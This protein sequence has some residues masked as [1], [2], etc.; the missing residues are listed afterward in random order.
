M[1]ILKITP[2]LLTITI[3]FNGCNT[4]E[5]TDKPPETTTKATILSKNTLT[6]TV[7]TNV[8]PLLKTGQTKTYYNFDD[9]YYQKGTTKNYTRDNVNNIVTD[10]ITNLMWQDDSSA[11]INIKS[12]YG[13]K[14]YCKFLTLGVDDNWRL[15]SRKELVSLIDYGKINPAISPVFKNV[16]PNSYWSSTT[17]SNS[18]K[19]A[20]NVYFYHGNQHY[21]TKYFNYS[22]RCVKESK[23]VN[24]TTTS[25]MWQDNEASKI[26]K[27]TWTEAIDYCESLSFA[28]FDDWRLPNL[29]EL[30]SIGNR[31][32]I[33]STIKNIFVNISPSYYW[34]STTNES[35]TLIARNVLFLN[36]NDSN[37]N[38]KNDNHVRCV[39][40]EE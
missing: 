11:K 27:K 33:N 17:S 36:G 29:N 35:N 13:A 23:V 32:K 30:Y 22:V 21:G 3:L 34:S 5:T 38:K 18:K 10:N 20:W 24:D 2:I 7:I 31:D 14:F 39:R 15:P 8:K 1:F 26:V 28:G 12:W 37:D 40:N 19:Y 9:G 4:K 16:I 25:L 6:N